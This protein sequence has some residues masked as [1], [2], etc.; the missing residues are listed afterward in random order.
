[1]VKQNVAKL[2]FRFVLITG[3]VSFFADM[4]YEGAPRSMPDLMEYPWSPLHEF[5]LENG[6]LSCY[7]ISKD[8]VFR[9]RYSIHYD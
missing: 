4:T 1:M 6:L 5:P 8:S 2:A 9:C 3:I 7:S